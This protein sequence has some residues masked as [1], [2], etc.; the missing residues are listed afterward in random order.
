VIKNI[1]FTLIEVLIAMLVL[2]V[3]LLGLASLQVKSLSNTQSAYNRSLATMLAYDLVERM[4]ANIIEAR[5]YEASAYITITPP[6]LATAQANCYI[7]TGCSENRMANN[8]LFE[9]N[10]AV[11]FNLP[12]GVVAITVVAPIYTITVTWDDNHDGVVNAQDPGFTTSFQ[13]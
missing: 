13:L 2:A 3:G 8:D 9:W 6:T 5:K 7:A 4:R 10:Q 1:G 12:S 11:T